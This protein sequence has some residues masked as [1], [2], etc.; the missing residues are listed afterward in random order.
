LQPG[1]VE[2]KVMEAR[3]HTSRAGNDKLYLAL[4]TRDGTFINEYITPEAYWIGLV[5]RC[6]GL[7]WNPSDEFNEESLVDLKGRVLTKVEPA[8]GDW[9][10]KLRVAKWLEP[11]ESSAPAAPAAPAAPVGAARA[12]AKPAARRAPVPAADSDIPF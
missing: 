4:R 10:E 11:G 3:P 9:P 5:A 7:E 8:N 2:V 1:E 12:T 6:F